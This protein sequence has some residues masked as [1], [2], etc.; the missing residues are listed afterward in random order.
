MA[1]DSDAATPITNDTP[2]V[3]RTLGEWSLPAIQRLLTANGV[4]DGRFDWKEMFPRDQGGKD[5]LIKCATSMANAGGGFLVFGVADKGSPEQRIIG[6]P[7]DQEFYRL[8]A[9]QLHRAD[10]PIPYRPLNPP[11]HV[12]GARTIYIIQVLEMSAPHA[13]DGQYFTRTGGG[14]DRR[15]STH[16]LRGLFRVQ[17]VLDAPGLHEIGKIAWSFSQPRDWDHVRSSLE[18][19]SPYAGEGTLKQK[20]AVLE[21]LSRLATSVRAGMPDD[22]IS[23]LLTQAKQAMPYDVTGEPEL[24]GRMLIIAADVAGHVGYDASL[25]LRDGFAVF[26]SA[27]LLASCLH[28]AELARRDD[29]KKAILKEFDMCIDA[30]RR[31]TPKPFTD[32][33]RWFEHRRSTPGRGRH[34]PP[35]RLNRV[36]A[37]LLQLHRRRSVP[38]SPR[39][40]NSPAASA[41]LSIPGPPSTTTRRLA[42]PAIKS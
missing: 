9:D 41:L 36:E 33:A 35:A 26:Q 15:L 24:L 42:R 5:R 13:F 22:V 32:A 14:S 30:A 21:A 3:P 23:E 31:A 11:L 12:T 6:V 20:K 37:R 29:A 10:P 25:Y 19:L 18:I 2:E 39:G 28:M 38:E 27:Q 17:D 4:E 16:E 34:V 1:G 40:G 8:L 7:T